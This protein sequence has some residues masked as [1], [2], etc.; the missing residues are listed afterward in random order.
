MTKRATT[1]LLSGPGLV[2]WLTRTASKVRCA[3]PWFN[4]YPVKEVTKISGAFGSSMKTMGTSFLGSTMMN[5]E[6]P[7]QLWQLTNNGWVAISNV[8]VTGAPPHGGQQEN[9]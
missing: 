7:Y 5:N 2:S 9:E 4:Q 3:F 6:P 8:N 1:I